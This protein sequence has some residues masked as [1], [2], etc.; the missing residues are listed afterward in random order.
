MDQLPIVSLRSNFLQVNGHTLQADILRSAATEKL[1]VSA[2]RLET[3]L[4]L[5][6]FSILRGIEEFYTQ[7]K[8]KHPGQAIV[9][10]SIF[11][12][13]LG[14]VAQA[15]GRS[16]RVFTAE[17]YANGGIITSS[18]EIQERFHG[19]WNAV[20]S[21]GFLPEVR[22]TSGARDG[23]AWLML[24]RPTI[25]DVLDEWLSYKESPIATALSDQIKHEDQADP[26][27]NMQHIHWYREIGMRTIDTDVRSEDMLTLAHQNIGLELAIGAL[28]L[29]VHDQQGFVDA[30]E[31][32]MRYAER[33]PL[34]DDGVTFAIEN[35][36]WQA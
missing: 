17:G 23:G 5:G 36:I 7:T 27:L 4:V 1:P 8:L 14:T 21:A 28:K 26:A 25:P 35:A 29:A 24:R 18:S 10:P 31:D 34:V 6:R 30:T 9:R 3:I 20:K 15:E 16:S 2:E 12:A 19:H 13:Q 11:T 32:A 22:R 33:H